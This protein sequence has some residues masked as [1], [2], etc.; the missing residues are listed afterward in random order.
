MA[1]LA[2]V[3]AGWA[4]LT[5][6]ILELNPTFPLSV[7]FTELTFFTVGSSRSLVTRRQWDVNGAEM[8]IVGMSA[9]VVVSTI[10]NLLS[11]AV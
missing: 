11:G 5:P 9:A 1:F 8:F 7:T 6:Y 3:I 10:G 2:F 4:P